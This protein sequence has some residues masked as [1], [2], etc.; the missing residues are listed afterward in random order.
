MARISV[1]PVQQSQGVEPG[2]SPGTK[3]VPLDQVGRAAILNRLQQCGARGFTG[4][5]CRSRHLQ[6]KV[7]EVRTVVDSRVAEISELEIMMRFLEEEALIVKSLSL[8][9]I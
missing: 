3:T 5:S 4:Y 7:V 2:V 1:D 6:T 8:I 9:H